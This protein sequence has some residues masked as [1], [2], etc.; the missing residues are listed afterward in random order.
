MESNDRADTCKEN[1]QIG[2]LI[3]AR[4]RRQH[5]PEQDRQ[6]LGPE[7]RG[8]RVHMKD[9]FDKLL[10]PSFTPRITPTQ[11]SRDRNGDSTATATPHV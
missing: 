7:F 2:R 4:R 5:A 1:L 9:L 11:D 10:L 3:P 8:R 6:A